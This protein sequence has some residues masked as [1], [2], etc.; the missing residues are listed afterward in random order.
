MSPLEGTLSPWAAVAG[1]LPPNGPPGAQNALYALSGHDIAV[2]VA[3]AIVFSLCL[4]LTV[5]IL[6]LR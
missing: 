6:V 5:T 4:A 3:T 2:L 1:H